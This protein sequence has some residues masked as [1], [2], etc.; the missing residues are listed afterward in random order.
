MAHHLHYIA[1]VP[2]EVPHADMPNLIGRD[3]RILI[4][5]FALNPPDTEYNSVQEKQPSRIRRVAAGVG[6]IA[7][8]FPGFAADLTRS[9]NTT[10]MQQWAGMVP[11]WGAT[12]LRSALVAVDGFAYA[13]EALQAGH[14]L[15]DTVRI[16]AKSVLAGS[17]LV[18]AHALPDNAISTG[19]DNAGGD[20]GHQSD[21][22]QRVLMDESLALDQHTS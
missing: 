2:V 3:A 21:I 13:H 14:S 22:E 8:S 6:A 7:T 4:E 11:A 15:E 12:L 1:G 9:G 5:Q 19:E 16:S 20:H 18:Q 17:S 10:L